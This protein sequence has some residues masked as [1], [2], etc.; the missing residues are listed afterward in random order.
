MYGQQNNTY[1]QARWLADAE[2]KF[3]FPVS[4]WLTE[5]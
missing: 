2:D 3:T 5:M 1:K 4:D